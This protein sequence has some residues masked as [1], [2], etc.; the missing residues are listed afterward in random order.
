M[1]TQLATGDQ[2][3]ATFRAGVLTLAFGPHAETV[4]LRQ[5]GEHWFQ[6][7]KRRPDFNGLSP[8]QVVAKY[9][10]LLAWRRELSKTRLTKP[11]PPALPETGALAGAEPGKTP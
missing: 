5:D 3:L 9:Q 4:Q 8:A 2:F 6:N 11:P 1:S 10:Q 7:G